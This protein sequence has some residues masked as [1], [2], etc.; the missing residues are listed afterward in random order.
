MNSAQILLILS[1][2]PSFLSSPASSSPLNPLIP[3]SS[4]SVHSALLSSLLSPLLCL[5]HLF[6][7]ISESKGKALT[8][9]WPPPFLHSVALLLKPRKDDHWM[10]SK[11]GFKATSEAIGQYNWKSFGI[12]THDCTKWGAF[13]FSWLCERLWGLQLDK[14]CKKTKH[15][16]N[17]KNNLQHLD[18]MYVNVEFISLLCP[19]ETCIGQT[20]K[21]ASQSSLTFWEMWFLAQSVAANVR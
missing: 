19:P 20:F 3:L 21:G 14:T 13:C 15:K 6:K 4:P 7:G 12:N 1:S 2:N 9:L 17:G 18:E 8:F 10:G 16:Q 11:R 5:P